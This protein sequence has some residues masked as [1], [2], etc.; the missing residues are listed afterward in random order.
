MDVFSSTIIPTVNRPTLSRAISSVLEQAFSA[1]DFEVI[2]VND[3]GQ[4]MPDTDWRHSERVR[5]IDTNRRERSVARNTGAAIARG[6]YLHFLDDDDWLLP[7]A[8]DALW[9]LDQT[10]DAVWLYGSYQ[11]VD[12]DGNLI[13][14]FHPGIAGNIFALLVAGEGIPF[15]VSLLQARQ[16]Y[17]VGG[18]DPHPTITGVEDRDLGRRMALTGAV[19]YTPAIVAKIRIGQQG[20]TTN[21]ATLAESDRRGREKVLSA[22]NAF[23]R[24]RGSANSSYWRGRVSRAYFASMVWNL[25]RKNIFAAASRAT[26]GLVL[27][28]AHT[29]SADFWHGLRT[30]IK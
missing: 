12:N 19:A 26:A 9:A 15:Q 8:L 11:T 3:S 2:V 22:Q 17:A 6:K 27:A 29:L 16:F 18:F 21:W 5:V 4:P 10:S 14:E 23:A 1:A 25:R 7:G 13:E 30:K 28:G 20:S 24:L